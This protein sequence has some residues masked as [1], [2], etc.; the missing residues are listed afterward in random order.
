MKSFSTFLR[1]WIED[2]ERINPETFNIGYMF[3]EIN[4]TVFDNALPGDIP[5]RFGKVPRGSTGI[6]QYKVRRRV[7]ASI[8][9]RETIEGSLEIVIAPLKFTAKKLKGILAHEMIHALLALRNTHEANAHGIYFQG[10]RAKYEKIAGFPIPLTD[11]VDVDEY[12]DSDYKTSLLM[13]CDFNGKVAFGNFAKKNTPTMPQ[14][15]LTEAVRGGQTTWG[16]VA[17]VRSIIT[18]PAQRTFGANPSIYIINST[19]LSK[20][21]GG[22]IL[23]TIGNPP[24]EYL[25]V[26]GRK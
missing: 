18:A 17:M 2:D 6:C 13:V 4:R 5:V 11:T 20:I 10:A 21:A 16:I 12:V 15:W 3:T 7:G 22:E 8:S 26:M 9:S 24:E 1:E 19:F 23:Y 25:S 14:V